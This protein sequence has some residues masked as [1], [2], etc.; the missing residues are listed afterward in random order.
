M[1]GCWNHRPVA[2][3]VLT[4]CLTM[5]GSLSAQ[6]A[7]ETVRFPAAPAPVILGPAQVEA[8]RSIRQLD[9]PTRDGPAVFGPLWLAAG[10]GWLTGAAIG[11]ALAGGEFYALEP[12]VAVGAGLGAAVGAHLANQRRGR[13]LMDGLIAVA[14]AIPAVLVT[15]P[16]LMG[17]EDLRT[18]HLVGAG[19]VFLTVQSSAAVIAE[20]T[21][22]SR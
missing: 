18:E 7:S 20:Q 3:A 8:A 10:A 15:G 5:V 11:G 17:V 14:A 13:F 16:F 9:L 6:E 21:W 12:A 22:L 4:T 1:R 2:L 19:L